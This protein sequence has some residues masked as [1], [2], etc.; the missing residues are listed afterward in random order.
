MEFIG[1]AR[2]IAQ[3]TGWQSD[4][5]TT[6]T[7]HWH[8]NRH[9]LPPSF[10]EYKK[11]SDGAWNK[12]GGIKKEYI[13]F[14]YTIHWVELTGLEPDTEYEYRLSDR[15]SMTKKFK[16]MPEF[17][18]EFTMAIGGDYQTV[19]TERIEKMAKTV[20]SFD[21]DVHF[22]IGDIA[23]DDGGR[24]K[25][26]WPPFWQAVAPNLIKSNG[27]TI[28]FVVGL[29]NHEV[30]GGYRQTKEEAPYF[31]NMFSFPQ[32]G[33]G[34]LEFGDLLKVIILD[35]G[36]TV[37]YED[38]VPFLQDE[39]EKGKDYTHTLP[40]YHV[41][42]YPSAESKVDQ[43]AEDTKE[44]FTP[45]IEKEYTNISVVFEH[46]NHTFKRTPVISNGVRYF[47]DGCLAMPPRIVLDY[48]ENEDFDDTKGANIDPDNVNHFFFVTVKRDGWNIKAANIDGVVFY[49]TDVDTN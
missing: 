47:G 29:G 31:Y 44:Y 5:S 25:E 4:P 6:M 43:F 10:V 37:P 49:E 30:D 32:S 33:Y 41:A 26:R 18:E 28:P 9:G 36:H 3:Y 1:R 8:T 23:S 42:A 39:I 19:N 22:C 13:D 24:N 16:T 14:P 27:Q 17:P 21:P 2:V 35:T 38:Q 34:T 48:E 12:V 45:E 11:T 7:I 20:A 46:H 40:L 15:D